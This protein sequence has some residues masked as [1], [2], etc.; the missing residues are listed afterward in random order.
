MCGYGYRKE[1]QCGTELETFFL[2]A[3]CHRSREYYAGY[4]VSKVISGLFSGVLYYL[5]YQLT[6]KDVANCKT[7]HFSA[8]SQCISFFYLFIS[9]LTF[10]ICL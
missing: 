10:K 5:P 3:N 4:W 7:C 1:N 9:G 2:T 6:R 8:F